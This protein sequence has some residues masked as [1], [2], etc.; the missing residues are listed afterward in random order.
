MAY[1]FR[2][3]L[4][5]TL[6][7][8]LTAN[9]FYRLDSPLITDPEAIP[10]CKKIAKNLVTAT[11]IT[12][13]LRVQSIN[14]VQCVM[15]R[16]QNGAAITD[17]VVTSTFITPPTCTLP[18][19]LNQYKNTCST[20]C[21]GDSYY[22]AVGCSCSGINY[23]QS[24]QKSGG[25]EL[26]SLDSVCNNGCQYSVNASVCGNGVCSIFFSEQTGSAC[27][28]PTATNETLNKTTPEQDCIKQGLGFAT[29]NGTTTCAA[30]STVGQTIKEASNNTTVN[31]SINDTKTTTTT[32][33]T[34]TN[35]S[36]VRTTTTST[37]SAGNIT[38]TSKDETKDNFCAQ[39]PNVKICKFDDSK[40]SGSCSTNYSCTGDAVQCAIAKEQHLK[41][42][43]LFTKTTPL[44]VKGNE[45][46][47]DTADGSANNPAKVSNRETLNVSNMI[48][49][50]SNIGS[51]TFQDKNILLAGG[52]LTLPF[53][54]LNFI[55]QIL[56]G[57]ILAAAY[58][59]AARI[60]GV[61]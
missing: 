22:S 32:N 25:L 24:S 3:I 55:M 52:G 12:T 1:L 19:T 56:G 40:F 39:N 17:L 33:T 58:L 27:V 10:Q 45:M 16:T 34:I 43:E 46:L 35:D 11:V 38:T 21:A 4:L 6:C 36:T 49:E 60:V 47:S 50:G 59:N 14:N 15:S 28:T 42:C 57:F 44:T 13:Y 20:P 51:G 30:A 2:L 5:I 29:I 53:S 54:K 37:D 26:G 48:Q 18:L 61:R 7:T 23:P 8:S 31:S 9:A 41:N